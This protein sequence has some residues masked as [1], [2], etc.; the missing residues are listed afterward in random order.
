MRTRMHSEYI[1]PG[2]QGWV[3]RGETHENESESFAEAVEQRL[4]SKNKYPTIRIRH[5]KNDSIVIA[6]VRHEAI[7]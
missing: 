6:S 2:T 4:V 7:M 1:H 5:C 3:F